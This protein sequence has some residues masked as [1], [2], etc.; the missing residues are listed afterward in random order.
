MRCLR[1]IMNIRWQDMVANVEVLQWANTPSQFLTISSRRFRWMGHVKRMPDNC[2]PKQVLYGKLLSGLRP[3]G[4][5][6]LRYKD[7]CKSAMSDFMIDPNA[8]EGLGDG[9]NCLE[10]GHSQRSWDVRES[11][12]IRDGRKSMQSKGAFNSSADFSLCVLWSPLSIEYRQNQPWET[13]SFE[14]SGGNH[15][16]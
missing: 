11:S 10:I 6:K 14:G 9:S 4:R 12:K 3:R 7:T 2:M 16:L 15:K 8:L 5:P 13:M 1:R